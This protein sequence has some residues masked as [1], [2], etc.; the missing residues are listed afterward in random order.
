LK[1][2]RRY[3]TVVLIYSPNY[4]HNQTCFK[5]VPRNVPLVYQNGSGLQPA[6]VLL[7]KHAT[8][9]QNGKAATESRGG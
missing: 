7:N 3:R 9:M 4:K 2:P 8:K 6:V 5:D 1:P